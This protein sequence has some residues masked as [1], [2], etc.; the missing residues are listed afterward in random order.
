MYRFCYGPF[1]ISDPAV[2]SSRQKTLQILKD[3]NYPSVTFVLL[4]KLFIKN[5]KIK[6][7]NFQR[8]IERQLV[9]AV[10]FARSK[11]LSKME[12]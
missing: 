12:N 5:K 4:E 7:V 3:A 8:N 6:N 1:V 10:F 9:F 11:Q 2:L